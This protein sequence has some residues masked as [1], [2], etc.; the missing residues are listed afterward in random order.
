MSI[1]LNSTPG[2]SLRRNY[3]P[4]EAWRA[5]A[6]AFAMVDLAS[7]NRF[8]RYGT[9]VVLVHGVALALH[10]AAHVQL[11][12]FLSQIP[13]LFIGVVIFIAPV[14]AAVLLW[15]GP[16]SFG[17]WLLFASMIGSLIFGGY[18]HFVIDSPDHVA[19][20]PSGMWGA[21]FVVSAVMMSV[22]EVAGCGIGLWAVAAFRREPK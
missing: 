7:M 12:I 3:E 13:N 8:A 9:L 4:V 2:L 14:A 16:R 10:S 11:E 1:G 17:A 21:V 6:R 18:H 22:N 20:V 19:R 15:T 5:S